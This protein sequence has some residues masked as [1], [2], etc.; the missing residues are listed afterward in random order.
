MSDDH[1]PHMD[2]ANSM[3]VLAGNEL[4]AEGATALVPALAE[5]KQ[6]QNLDLSSTWRQCSA[7]RVGL[8]VACV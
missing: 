4:K 8:T 3:C 5:L 1:Y 7:L 6:L 2:R